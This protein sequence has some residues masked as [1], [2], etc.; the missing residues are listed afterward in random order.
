[1]S[2]L[3]TAGSV[4]GTIQYMSPE[5][6]EGLEVDAR[7]DIFAFGALLYEM[8]TGKPAFGGK[9]QITVAS[10]ILEKEPAPVSAVNPVAPPAL[11]YL[12]ATCLAK[13]REQR[14][15]SAHD[16]RLQ[17]R[18]IAETRFG[19]ATSCGQTKILTT[20]MDRRPASCCS[21]R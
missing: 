7:S 18:W 9:S 17:L 20:R 4:V 8:A 21:S 14:F 12:V 2:P 16:V 19:W 13:D 1:M 15:Q 5:Q 10:A 11:D 6:L 3:T